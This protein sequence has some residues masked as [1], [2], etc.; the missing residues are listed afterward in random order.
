ML[1]IL[2]RFR[3]ERYAKVGK[4]DVAVLGG[5]DVGSFE[6]TVNDSLSVEI[7]K[8]FEDLGGV[9]RDQCFAKTTK[10][11]DQR[12]ERAIL[13]IPERSQS[14]IRVP[15]QVHLLQYDVERVVIPFHTFVLDD[16]RMTQTPEQFHLAHDFVRLSFVHP[17]EAYSL[18]GDHLA[19]GH[20]ECFVNYP[21][22]ATSD[23]VAELLQG[24]NPEINVDSSITLT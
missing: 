13:D 15:S 12:S 16:T 20:V 7:I 23:A 22:L 14:M 4:L 11:L 18:D 10:V 1:D 9:R 21:E 5:K 2:D 24:V 6:I 8:P 17:L 3:V 19:C